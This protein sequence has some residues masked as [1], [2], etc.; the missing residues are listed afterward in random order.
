MAFADQTVRV[1]ISSTFRDMHA[2]RDHLVTVVFPE[3]RERVERLGLEFFDV[4]L[5]WG[6]PTKD[7]SGETANS[8]EY[9][10][11]WIDR[12]EPFFVCILGQRYG[13]VPEAS[14][15]KSNED[16]I[17]QAQEQR[18]IT[19]LEVR[20]GVLSN[21]RKRRSYFY[22]RESAVPDLLPDA[23]DDQRLVHDDFVDPPKLLVK[24]NALKADIRHCGRPARNYSCRWTGRQFGEFDRVEKDRQFGPMVLEDLWSGVLR[25]ER[26]VSKEIW[27]KAL[28]AD[29]DNDPL[30]MDE[31][32]PV[33][34]ELWERI[35]GL[36]KPAPMEPLE[37]ERE[38]MDV[39][40]SSRL[41][42][43]QGRVHELQTLGEF[44]NS[45]TIESPRLAVVAAQ[46][47]QGKSA[48][49]AKLAE[50]LKSSP[51]FVISHFVGA[52][53]HSTSAHSLVQ[54][55]LGELDRSGIVWAQEQQD[56][57]EPK[58]DFNS[59]CLQLGQRLGE[60]AGERRVLILLDALNQ[61]T[62][63]H[64]LQWL[65]NRLGNSVRVIVSCVVGDNAKEDRSE[66]H[67]L[68]ALLSRHPAPFR[69]EFGP[70]EKEDVRTIIVTYL[71]EYCHELDNEHLD[72]LCSIPQAG[73]PLYLLVMLNE[74]RT[75]GGNDLNRIVP[76]L[77]ESMPQDH[78]D[79]VSLFRWVLQR[80]EVFGPESVRLWC[81]YLAYG[82]VGMASS[83][84]ADLL[85]RELGAPAAASALRIER[86]LR[87]YLQRRGAQLDF[88]HGQLRNAA[89]EQYGPHVTAKKIHQELADYFTICAEGTNPQRNWESEGVRGFSECVFHRFKS[90]DEAT[91][92][93]FLTDF[94]F[95]LHK[96]RVGLLEGV[97][98]DYETLL[99]EAI[100]EVAKRLEIW[101][102][103][104]REK[105]H[106]LRRGSD[107][108]PAHK[109]LL[110][111]AVEHADDSPLTIGAEQW[112][113]E[114]RC[115]WLW[116]RRVPRLQHVQMN[117]C[118]AVLEGHRDQVGGALALKNGRLLSWSDDR[119]LRLWEVHSGFCL[120]VLDGHKDH[121]GG[122]LE[123]SDGRVLSWSSGVIAT[124]YE[125]RLW[126]SQSGV[127]LAV[128]EGHTEGIGGALELGDGRILS[129]SRDKCLRLWDSQSGLCLAV[130][131]GHKDGIGGAL[132]LAN[133]HLISWSDDLT[134]RLWD[135]L[136]GKCLAVLA[137]HD[138][139]I[140]NAL[141]LRD[142]RV[143]SWSVDKTLWLWSSINGA[144]IKVLE[145][146]TSI[147]NGAIEL[148]D[149]RILSW[150]FDN[151]LR[152][153]DIVSGVCLSVLEGHTSFVKGAMELSAGRI[154]SWS[155]DHAL[156]LWDLDS[157]KCQA[158]LEG[159][160]GGVRGARVLTSGCIL[161]WSDDHT[162]RLWESQSGA[163]Q[164]VLEGHAGEVVGTLELVDE[165]VVSWS[166][167]VNLRLW[168]VQ[169]LANPEALARH[170]DLIRGAMLITDGRFLSWSHD[171]TLRIWDVQGGRC[172]AVLEGHTWWVD[173]ALV[174]TDGR[175][176]SWSDDGTLRIWDSHSGSCLV[177]LE[178]KPP[179]PVANARE[180]ADG[181]L[182][183][184][185]SAE[186]ASRLWDLKSGVCLAILKGHTE[187]IE[188][189]RQLTD[190]RLLSW[191][192]NKLQ[193]WDSGSGECLTDLEGHTD[194]VAGVLELADGRLLSWCGGFE[195]KET[196]L[197][198]WDSR[199][200]GCLAILE[201]HS[202]SV[203]GALE[204]TNRRLLTWSHDE[205]LRL[206][207]GRNGACLAVLKG[208]TEA[209]S[210]AMEMSDGRLLSWAGGYQS[211]DK[212]LRIWDSYSG[213]CLAVLE[214]HTDDS[215]R[216]ATE[217]AGGRLLSWSDNE[218][219]CLWD[220][221]SGARLSVASKGQWNP[222]WQW[223]LLQRN[224]RRVNL[225]SVLG[226]FFAATSSRMECL[227]HRC[228]PSDVASWNA[229]A[230]MDTFRYPDDL[231]PDLLADGTIIATR[232]DGQVCMLKLHHGGR[233][234]SLMEA[235]EYLDLPRPEVG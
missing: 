227:R 136:N 230:Q 213:A 187:G 152:R 19:D 43:F 139:L 10:R 72:R 157:G 120:A 90:G 79:T 106:I 78:P 87:R 214:G 210:G 181:R 194:D 30:Y 204:L 41:R 124:G 44:L 165:K 161:S 12:V 219:A 190:G 45:R 228:F 172:L 211:K 24:L 58:L 86:G 15:F 141:E 91:A 146:H 208:H 75:L 220:A 57:Q 121:V 224:G 102:D 76:A 177:R 140:D 89:L 200:G 23:T 93:D 51:D 151:T 131:E 196:S 116:L 206:W 119:T 20:H 82:R 143:L 7:V 64:N 226:D 132:E 104:F 4:D 171:H 18:S 50:Q 233:R 155:D 88:F 212:S 149:G 216:G 162:L 5:R 9:C 71:T 207:D 54:R 16:R 3:L 1:F 193:L 46:P 135:S 169:S 184:W 198:I 112:L 96:V 80:L 156:R 27:R 83:E 33:P 129:W 8:W 235:A 21:R 103:F 48:L 22:L 110:Q 14:D 144:C 195:S 117:P 108:W 180:L 38:Q 168:D 49:M 153:W 138:H 137:G 215:I 148:V 67:V 39:F 92:A 201:G 32:R 118:L 166:Y 85:A 61:L 107:E 25:D 42:W 105:A 199:T 122:A 55:L 185:S 209:V 221:N 66:K 174:L 52:T 234:V 37:A 158:V 175:L 223:S 65:P 70:L 81:L 173:A 26:Y 100:S 189:A 111:L 95:L 94:S 98:E 36:A 163:K 40:A 127:C 191:E 53:E 222:E 154:L 34:C 229:E 179:F 145:G 159:H 6:V 28:G 97:F 170:F 69:A 126:E 150:S 29:P 225:N 231:L 232:K 160:S 11:Q 188:G 176:L 56:G 60:Y 114:G 128:L 197:R 164:A 84:L 186:G 123:L 134:L 182:L 13:W 73:N 17:R 178:A 115:E 218:E 101:S 142:E 192:D 68:E 62:D 133:G 113:A 217:L 109:I 205:T 2:E 63:G 167:D 125:L 74:L 47:G 99:S 35:V 31:S 130:L 77:I 59:V 183:S 202:G 203:W 147:V